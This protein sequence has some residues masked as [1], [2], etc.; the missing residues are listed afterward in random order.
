[1]R[2]RAPCS[3]NRAGNGEPKVTEDIHRRRFLKQFIA[4][5]TP[6]LNAVGMNVYV[7]VWWATLPFPQYSLRKPF[8]PRRRLMIE[9]NPAGGK[10]D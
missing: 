4:E 1:M 7:G 2:W 6:D 5:Q 8:E 10:G 9:G 3:L